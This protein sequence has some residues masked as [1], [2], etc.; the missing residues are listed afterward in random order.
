MEIAFIISRVFSDRFY[1][2]Q[3]PLEVLGDYRENNVLLTTS[4]SFSQISY[5]YAF[6]L[7]YISQCSSCDD[8]F[9]STTDDSVTPF[10]IL[11]V[12]CPFLVVCIVC[13]RV[14][15]TTGIHLFPFP[16]Y[17]FSTNPK[18]LDYLVM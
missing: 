14:S 1:D 17:Q 8:S 18:Y 4:C 9:S 16:C 10:G 15:F 13:Q 3:C 2:F 7:S 6:L 5:G 12:E 11:G